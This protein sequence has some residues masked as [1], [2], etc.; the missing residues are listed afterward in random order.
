M[1]RIEML[2]H[3]RWVALGGEFATRAA[4]EARVAQYRL[5][6]SKDRPRVFRIVS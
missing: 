6:G 2:E 5:A 3:D 1:F 4:A